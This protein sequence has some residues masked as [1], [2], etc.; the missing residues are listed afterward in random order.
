MINFVILCGGL[1]KRFQ[2][3]SRTLPKILIEIDKGIPMLDWL[4]NQYLPQNSR[5][6]LATGHLNEKI[7]KHIE[8][9]KYK[10]KLEIVEEKKALGTGGALINVSR[11]I[12]S[13]EFIALNGDTIQDLKINSFLRKSKL[14]KDF[15]I[16][17]GCTS[18]NKKDSGK[19]L[20]DKDNIIES[21]TEKKS[22]IKVDNKN[23]RLVSSLG[24][25]RCKT[26]FFLNEQIKNLSLE[27]DLLPKL[28]KIKKAKASIFIEDFQDYGTYERYHELINNRINK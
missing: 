20:I 25:Y 11:F 7:Q 14:N 12:D 8:N 23:Q 21:F 17:V 28:V 13:E 18:K 1:G 16:N 22:P 4:L 15:I 27:E 5:V 2:K 3:V 9:R 6:L 19:I 10:H 24:I 26:A